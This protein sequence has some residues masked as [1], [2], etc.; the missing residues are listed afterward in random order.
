MVNKLRRRSSRK[1]EGIA[2]NYN[3]LLS[4]CNKVEFISNRFLLFMKQN[5]FEIIVEKFLVCS[6]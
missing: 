4:K 6:K 2:R 3:I 1:L 5:I